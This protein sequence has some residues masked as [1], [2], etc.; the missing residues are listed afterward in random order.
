M[1]SPL[2]VH[3]V[4][5]SPM[6]LTFNLSILFYIFQF[7]FLE[8]GSY[9]PCPDFDLILVVE[10]VGLVGFADSSLLTIGGHLSDRSAPTERG[11]FHSLDAVGV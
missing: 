4:S 8:Q 9:V 7:P 10:F 5:F 6:I 3:L 11:P 1:K 2:L